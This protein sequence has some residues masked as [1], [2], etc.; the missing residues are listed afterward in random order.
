LIYTISYLASSF[1]L[2]HGLGARKLS[3]FCLSR[4]QISVQHLV[5]RT[6]TVGFGWRRAFAKGVL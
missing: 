4:V 3:R 5:W 6:G 1:K 2:R